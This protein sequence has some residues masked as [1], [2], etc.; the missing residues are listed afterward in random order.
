MKNNITAAGKLA[1]DSQPQA[2]YNGRRMLFL[3]LQ[4]PDLDQLLEKHVKSTNL[5]PVRD[6]VETLKAKVSVYFYFIN[7]YNIQL[8]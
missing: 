4:Q 2:R 5:K 1:V 8:Y 7:L 6:I 3:I